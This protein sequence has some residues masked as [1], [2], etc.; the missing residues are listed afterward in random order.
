MLYCSWNGGFVRFCR[1]IVSRIIVINIALRR[2]LQGIR[3][4]DMD[5]PGPYST[6]EYQVLP[7]PHSKFVAFISPLEGTLVLKH[8]LDYETLKNFTVVLRAQ[9][10]GSPPKYSDSTLTVFVLDAD[11]QNPKFF[12]DVYHGSFQGN[13]VP[14]EVM[15]HTESIR[16]IDQDS[17]L[18]ASLTYS[19]VPSSHSKFFTIDPKTAVLKLTKH[20][21]LSNPITLVVKATQL[22]NNDRYA[23][24]TVILSQKQSTVVETVDKASFMQSTYRLKIKE[25]YNPG[26]T[27]LKLIKGN[28][29]W[30]A[31]LRILNDTELYWFS[32]DRNGNIKLSRWLDFETKPTHKFT[33]EL[34]DGSN[35]EYAEVLVEVLDVNDWEPRFRKPHYTFKIRNRNFSTPLALGKVEAADG[36]VRDKITYS[37][38]G[39]HANLFYVDSGGTVWL[40]YDV[41]DKMNFK[42][43]IIAT[44]TGFPPK[45]TIV[46]LTVDFDE[47]TESAIKWTTTTISALAGVTVLCVLAFLAVLTYFC[48]SS[49]NRPNRNVPMLISRSKASNKTSN[50]GIITANTRGSNSSIS[51][52]ASTIIAASLERDQDSYTTTIRGKYLQSIDIQYTLKHSWK[53]LEQYWLEPKLGLK[54]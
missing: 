47:I 46:P 23:L 51:A 10:Q 12:Q 27:I 4:L 3:A 34:N 18:N 17:G 33:V 29:A 52:S 53:K 22:D 39:D 31:N 32:I 21:N 42:L 49:V 26:S 25:N 11:D 45:S 20:L 40:K 37:L 13:Q 28:M 48:R 16:A 7:G 19:I 43:H 1:P 14:S 8:E 35:R 36:D 41:P 5:Q 38:R 50:I 6:I 30:N 15:F 2:I 9:D 54:T 44:D 24:S